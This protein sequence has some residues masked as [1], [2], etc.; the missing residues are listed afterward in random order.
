MKVTQ[1]A[2]KI[3]DF[4]SNY[5]NPTMSIS[6]SPS[7]FVVT[8]GDG[9][10]LFDENG[11]RYLDCINNVTHI[12]HCNPKYI[13]YIQD[14]L[15]VLNTNARFLFDGLVETTEKLLRLFPKELSV[16]TWACSG[17]EAN[18]LALQMAKIHT[19]RNQLFCLQDAYHGHTD[20]TMLVSPYKWNDNFKKSPRVTVLESACQYRGIYCASENSSQLYAEKFAKKIQRKK[21]IAGFIFEPM[22]SCAGQIIPKDDYF[23]EMC[24][25]AHEHGG[26]TIADEIQTGFGRLGKNFWAF[27]H[28]GIIPDIVTVGK[29][30]GNGFPVSAVICRKEIA[31]SFYHQGIEYASSYAGNP[32]SN[33][34]VSAVIDTMHESK[35]QENALA[36]GNYLRI[37]LEKLKEFSCV[38]DVRGFGFFFGL[39]IVRNKQTREPFKQLAIQI[40]QA[41]CERGVLLSVDGVNKNVIK[42]KPPMVFSKEDADQM[43]MTLKSA[44]YKA[45]EQFGMSSVN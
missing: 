7:P 33:A 26:V 43:L 17:S 32:L 12:G 13:K 42:M 3:I 9:T 30:M 36:I 11:K 40:R 21:G 34:A 6:Y 35:L 18:D 27:E 1:K 5:L 37:G 14:Q 20:L 39:D 15:P 23:Q 8:R 45:E 25:V 29:A 10:S 16:V 24:R 38:G 31:E 2:M 44:I 22:Q 4:R 41:A 28:Y 19:G